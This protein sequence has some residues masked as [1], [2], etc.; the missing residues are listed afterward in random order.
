MNKRR[1]EAKSEANA[2]SISFLFF[3][4]KHYSGKADPNDNNQTYDLGSSQAFE[5]SAPIDFARSGCV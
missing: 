4:L 5:D 2:C 1:T 3:P